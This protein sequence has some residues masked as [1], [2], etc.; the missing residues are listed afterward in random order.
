MFQDEKYSQKVSAGMK[1]EKVSQDL[2]LG[3]ILVSQGIHR[4]LGIF[5]FDIEVLTG[6][7]VVEDYLVQMIQAQL[8]LD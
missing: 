5:H 1:V 7:L 8:I 6:L 4:G 3:K 2:K